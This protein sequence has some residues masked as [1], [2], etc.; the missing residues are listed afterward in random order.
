VLPM[1]LELP[2][3]IC[4]NS[5]MEVIPPEFE[6]S[7]RRCPCCDGQGALIFER[8][9]KCDLLTLVCDEVGTIFANPRDLDLATALSIGS[10]CPRC[11]APDGNA[12]P[13]T[14][15]EIRNAGFSANEFC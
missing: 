9:K 7:G 1:A 3:E 13:A 14:S 4:W 5:R 12:R 6:L 8:C 15:E 11:K 2:S 10:P